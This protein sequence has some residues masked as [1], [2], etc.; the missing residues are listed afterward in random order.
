MTAA[1][2]RTDLCR[3]ARWVIALVGVAMTIG[4]ILDISVIGHRK[5]TSGIFEQLRASFHRPHDDAV[6]KLPSILHQ[7]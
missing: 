6:Q 7:Q 4:L 2:T 1:K 3:V 5:H